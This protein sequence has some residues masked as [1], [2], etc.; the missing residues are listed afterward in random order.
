MRYAIYFTPAQ[1]DPLTRIAANWLGR[2]PFT[3]Q[4]TAAPA[5]GDLTPAEIAFNTAAARRYGFHATLKAPFRLVETET[6]NSLSE[7]LT[8]Y[9]A[10]IAPVV[11]P[12]IVVKRIDGFFALMPAETVPELNRLADDIVAA[13]DRFRAPLTEAEI[14]RRNPDALSPREFRNLCQWGYPFV[15]EAF[16]FH[17][18]LSGRIDEAEA[19]RVRAA[20]EA[21]FAPVLDRPVA[22]DGLAL[23]VEPE[24]GAP[25]AIQSYHPL[26]S[27]RER[28]FA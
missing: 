19:P 20:I 7:A 26:E 11:I 24:A 3:G 2:D 8:A 12:R 28:K 17:M 4:A 13:F 1:S 21:Y 18:T 27:R 22:V 10:S 15:F 5:V 25:F 9:A 16:R 23:F 6:E 14:A